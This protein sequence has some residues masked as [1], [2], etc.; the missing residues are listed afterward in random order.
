MADLDA[1]ADCRA[2][3][4]LLFTGRH[5]LR[6]ALTMGAKNRHRSAE[7]GSGRA[8]SRVPGVRRSGTR[9]AGQG[10]FANFCRKG[11]MVDPAKRVRKWQRPAV[12]VTNVDGAGYVEVASLGNTFEIAYVPKTLGQPVEVGS[13]VVLRDYKHKPKLNAPSAR[14]RVA[15]VITDFGSSR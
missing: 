15:K 4:L 5:D 13:K 11:R 7:F 6:E 14:F 12:V 1:Y 9:R 3:R 10:A 2:D 8:I